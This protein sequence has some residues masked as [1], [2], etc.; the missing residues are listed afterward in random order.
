MPNQIKNNQTKYY[1]SLDILCEHLHTQT[2]WIFVQ[3]VI[4]ETK[5]KQ[6]QCNKQEITI[7]IAMLIP[8]MNTN[9]G[10]EFKFFIYYF[11]WKIYLYLILPRECTQTRIQLPNYYNTT[12][13]FTFSHL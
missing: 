13:I 12:I 2:F 3:T 8:K 9:D 5:K 4:R 10:R 7:I 1:L 6:K 11:T